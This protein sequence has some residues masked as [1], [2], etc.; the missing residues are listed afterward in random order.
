MEKESLFRQALAENQ[1]RI[2]RICS[3]YFQDPAD[4][5]DAYQ[6]AL[7]RIWESIGGFKQKSKVSTWIYRVV[8]NTC[9]SGIRSDKRRNG[10]IDR[11]MVP[12]QL[13]M[14]DGSS[15]EGDREAEQKLAFFSEFMQQIP[16]FDRMLVSIY[17][18]GLDTREMAEITGLSESN[19]RVK[20]HR[21]KEQI[22]KEWEEHSHGTR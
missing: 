21:I 4:R 19:V 10:F 20:I 1:E 22:K 15:A 12:D 8:V 3:H 5:N 16:A 11:N 17:L 6:E 14:P 18:E 2:F 13:Q 9:L 7:I